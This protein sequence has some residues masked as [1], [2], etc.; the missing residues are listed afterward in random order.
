[1]KS[2]DLYNE[3]RRV[4][5]VQLM[6]CFTQKLLVNIFPWPDR[7]FNYK[8]HWTQLVLRLST[9]IKKIMKNTNNALFMTSPSFSPRQCAL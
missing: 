4:I 5:V 6:I 2:Y 9:P 3:I 1:M 7:L 8:A